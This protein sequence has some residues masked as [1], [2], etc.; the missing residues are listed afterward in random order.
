M[1]LVSLDARTVTVP[2]A[3]C[4][5]SFAAGESIWTESSY[6]YDPPHIDD[7]GA[8]AG[9]T[10]SERWT[11]EAGGFALTLFTAV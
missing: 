2:G 11:D 6:K 5:V 4:R 9:F 1:H 3:G 8:R 7:L 10:V